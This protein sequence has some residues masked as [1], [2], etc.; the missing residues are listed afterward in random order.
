MGLQ[1][2]HKLRVILLLCCLSIS[3]HLICAA[4]EGDPAKAAGAVT[5]MRRHFVL[6]H[7]QAQTVH[8]ELTE[9][10][11]M[12]DEW[13]HTSLLVRDVG[14]GEVI[15]EHRLSFAE[16]EASESISDVSGK[17]FIRSS[18]ATPWT[19]KTRKRTM[20][21]AARNPALAD[22]LTP[23]TITTPGGEWRSIDQEEK[24]WQR[25][26]EL[27]HSVRATVPFFLL[28]AAERM[29]GTV[30]STVTG[31][32]CYLLVGKYLVYEP[33]DESSLQL[34]EVTAAPDCAF[35]K[36]FGYP[37]SAQQLKRVE[38]AEKRGEVLDRY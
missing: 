32:S 37:C 2:L 14:H 31:K 26:R 12:S 10:I 19:S 20:E 23:V 17:A 38:A 36:A 6:R 13:S 30:F 5:E 3:G 11:R 9:I 29:R 27:R 24:D 25:L 18:S 16:H 7:N 35:D 34:E 4:P 22:M 1:K 21:E 33:D 28:E 15:C 8:F